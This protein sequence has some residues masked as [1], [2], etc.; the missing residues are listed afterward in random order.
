MDTLTVFVI[1]VFLSNCLAFKFIRQE[2]DENQLH[3]LSQVHDIRSQVFEEENY[4][5]DQKTKIPTEPIVRTKQGSVKGTFLASGQ[6]SFFMGIPYAAPPVGDLRWKAPTMPHK[7][8]GIYDA[9]AYNGVRTSCM[10]PFPMGPDY[11]GVYPLPMSEDCLHL[12]IFAPNAVPPGNG[13]PVL[14]FIHGGS[15]QIGSAYDFKQDGTNF[16]KKGIVVVN[17]NYRLNL[18]GFLKTP[19][20]EGNFGLLDQK[21]AMKWVTQ[22]IHFFGGDPTRVTISGQSS[23]ATSLNTHMIDSSTKGLFSQVLFESNTIGDDPSDFISI[24]TAYSFSSQLSVAVGCNSQSISCLRS[25]APDELMTVWITTAFSNTISFPG[26][27]IGYAQWPQYTGN[28]VGAY[29]TYKTP[30]LPTSPI[31]AMSQGQIGN[32][33]IKSILWGTVKDEGYS[34]LPTTVVNFSMMEAYSSSFDVIFPK[35]SWLNQSLTSPKAIKDMYPFDAACP[36]GGGF[37]AVADAIGDQWTTC[38]SR[39]AMTGVSKKFPNIS[40]YGYE[41]DYASPL[42]YSPGSTCDGSVGIVCHSAELNFVFNESYLYSLYDR[43]DLIVSN[44]IV[45][46]WINFIYTGNPNKGPA[47]TNPLGF[48]WNKFNAVTKTLAKF[49]PN[50]V[51]ADN[52]RV[53][54]CNLWKTQFGFNGF[55]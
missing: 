10:Q 55:I 50:P 49:L 14:I 6:V 2:L 18:F 40:F 29:P 15:Y 38:A 47:G 48:A 31:L 24:E 44:F 33:E 54:K 52:P 39:E 34:F 45:N 13:Y 36:F 1:A 42:T 26:G 16:A 46:T 28:I 23:G 51:L 11:F 4:Q 20:I 7:R 25:L 5:H 17:I 22:N 43:N 9:T 3:S 35:S 41:F 27:L 21:E 19:D 8:T 53:S 32:S 30:L 37:C 12:N